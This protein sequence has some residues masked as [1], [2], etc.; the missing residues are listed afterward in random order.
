MA[1]SR[2]FCGVPVLW[3]LSLAENQNKYEILPSSPK[4]WTLFGGLCPHAVD[5]ITLMGTWESMHALA[6]Q[7]RN[8]ASYQFQRFQVLGATDKLK[9]EIN[10]GN[11]EP[12]TPFHPTILDDLCTPQPHQKCKLLAY[13]RFLHN[14]A[15]LRER[16]SRGS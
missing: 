12:R 10:K 16:D 15:P 9:E 13:V 11:N 5:A 6:G 1:N 3:Y 2:F 14:N 7:G 8:L 4:K